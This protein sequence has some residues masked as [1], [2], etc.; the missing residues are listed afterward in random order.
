MRGLP[1]LLDVIMQSSAGNFSI[2]RE[3]DSLK[4]L[5]F[6]FNYQ[7]LHKAFTCTLSHCLHVS[8]SPESLTMISGKLLKLNSS[9][10][11]MYS[12]EYIEISDY[13]ISND[14]KIRVHDCSESHSLDFY[15]VLRFSLKLSHPARHSHL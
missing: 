8:K 13:Y 15:K 4:A 12:S 5:S 1:I 14:W 2:F 9:F 11:I 3:L 7:I 10:L 6:N